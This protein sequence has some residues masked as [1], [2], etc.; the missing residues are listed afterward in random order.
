[1]AKR[2]DLSHVSLVVVTTRNVSGATFPGLRRLAR[3]SRSVLHC[4]HCP[5]VRSPPTTHRARRHSVVQYI[6]AFGVAF[7]P[8]LVSIP[9]AMPFLDPFVLCFAE[10]LCVFIIPPHARTPNS[11]VHSRRAN[12]IGPQ[13]LH[14]WP[15]S[16]TEIL[17]HRKRKCSSRS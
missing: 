4:Y 15:L 3:R 6:S 7:F 1:M 14:I 16:A 5:V 10:F 9:Q 13:N 12:N 2:Q 8:N 17:H 11:T